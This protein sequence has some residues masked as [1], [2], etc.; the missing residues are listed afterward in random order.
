MKKTLLNIFLVLLAT[1]GMVLTG[2]DTDGSGSASYSEPDPAQYVLVEGGSYLRGSPD[3][4]FVAVNEQPQHEVR[5]SSFY[6][7]KYEVTQ[8]EW[9]DIM[10]LTVEEQ[11]TI[12]GQAA[13]N[14]RGSGDDLPINFVNW[15]DAV[16]FCNRLSKKEG[17]TP[18]YTV[19]TGG[20]WLVPTWDVEWNRSA[21]GWRLPT[22]AEW[23]YACRAGTTT[24]YNTGDTENDLAAAAWYA[25]NSTIKVEG[26]DKQMLHPVG[27]KKPNAWGIY[28]MHGNVWEW[29]Y[30]RYVPNYADYAANAPVEDP[31]G[32]D[33]EENENRVIRGGAFNNTVNI[34]EADGETLKTSLTSA[35]SD[36]FYCARRTGFEPSTRGQNNGFRIVRSK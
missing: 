2:C 29:C 22:E 34:F 9:K 33:K 23:E 15:K 12:S 8:K 27:T 17:L 16:E 19:T 18:A 4:D 32:A 7:G 20:D 31:I 25:K 14:F 5:V 21:E 24:R 11:H 6:I 3:V 35:A 13:A 26:A 1:V 30:D 36:F 10:G 28:D